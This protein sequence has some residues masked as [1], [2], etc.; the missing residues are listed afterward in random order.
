[1]SQL[2]REN[3]GGSFSLLH[4]G[5]GLIVMLAMTAVPLLGGAALSG[6]TPVAPGT[7]SGNHS[8]AISHATS[9]LTPFTSVTGKVYMSLTA[10]GTNTPAGGPVNVTKKT[11]RSTVQSAYLLAAAVPG[12]T[13]QDGTVTLDGTSLSFTPAHT[14][15][16]N[17]GTEA[18]WTNVTTIVAP[19]VDAAPPGLVTFTAAEPSNTDEITGEILAVVMN[20]PT[21]KT[22]NT[23]SFLFGALTTAGDTFH[24]GLS[25][26][27]KLS[28]PT[29]ALNM[30]IGDSYSYQGEPGRPTAQYSEITVNTHR[31]TSAAGGNDDSVCKNETPHNWSTCGNG[32]LITVGGIGD[33]TTDP[34]NPTATPVTCTTPPGPPRCTDELYTLLP[35]VK[36]GTTSIKVHTVNPSDNDD[37]FFSAF[38]LDGV[39]A[40]IGE[41]AV[42]TPLTGTSE[43]GSPYQFTA[44]VQNS[45]G[46]PYSSLPLTFTVL[47]GPNAGEKLTGT[48]NATGVATFTLTS[49]VTGNDTVQVSFVNGTMETLYSNQATVTWTSPSTKGYRLNGSDGG[50]FDFGSANFIGSNCGAVT[51]GTNCGRKLPEPV[52]GM[53]PTPDALGYWQ[54]SSNGKVSTYGDAKP[55][56]SATTLTLAAPI[57]G[58]VATPAGTGY[59]LTSADGGVFAYGT[60][61]FYGSAAKTKLAAPIVGIAATPDGKGYWL[62]GADGGVFAY[63]SARYHGGMGGKTLN[64][65]VV[66]IAAT[67]A[68]T[69]YWLVGADG[70]VF[71]FGTAKYQGGMGGKSLNAPVVGIAATGAGTGYWLAGADGGVFAFGGA[72]FAG[73]MVGTTLN[74]PI[75]GIT[76]A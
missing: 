20:D 8:Q 13:F 59:W 63:G 2:Q 5:L 58:M 24:I 68:G 76:A 74:K 35:F 11:S 28:T 60:A 73:S 9:G 7:V 33:S 40:V 12:F 38:Q 39:A 57:V 10:I 45:S 29:L 37:I 56:G 46:T 4:L 34:T 53:A 54:V 41:G 61:Q 55:Y 3:R 42:L 72:K 26:P 48:T 23:V 49:A 64:A 75:I 14:S 66:G 31:M 51:F 30:S 65:P 47:S 21:Q 25:S 22:G 44:K 67:G 52:V 17:F 18:F 32:E 19:V 50:V 36:T 71:S 70:G 43:V 69:G 6:A 1:M 62:V 16:V 15:L 27:L